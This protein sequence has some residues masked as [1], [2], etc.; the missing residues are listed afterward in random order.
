MAQMAAIQDLLAHYLAWGET[1]YVHCFGGIG[2]TETVIG[3]Y[4]VEQGMSGD[5][6]LQHPLLQMYLDGVES[7]EANCLY[8]ARTSAGDEEIHVAPTD[9]T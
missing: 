3:C 7:E 8:I 5:G 6:A 9:P 2:R 4:L 1:V